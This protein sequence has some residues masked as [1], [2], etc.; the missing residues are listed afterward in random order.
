MREYFNKEF[1]L[2]NKEKII[3]GA[4]VAIFVIISFFCFVLGNGEDKKKNITIENTA[5]SSV[6]AKEYAEPD[7]IM[8]D[9]CGEVKEPKVVQLESDS[10]VTD[11]VKAAGGFTENADTTQI[12]QAAFLTDGEKIYVPAKGEAVTDPASGSSAVQLKVDI[13][14]ATTEELQTLDGIGPVTAEKIV[15]YR[16]DVGRF[17]SIDELKNVSGIGEK[18]FDS[19]KEYIRV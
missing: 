14:T 11:A 6:D 10:R 18:T 15:K 8:V 19:L 5:A 12:N 13:N 3:K 7:M 2:S 4:A 9:V 1:I 16:N 17:K